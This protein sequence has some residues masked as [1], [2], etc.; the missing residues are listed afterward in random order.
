MLWEIL[1]AL[2]LMMSPVLS[3][4]AEELWQHMRELDKSLLDSVQLGDWPQISEQEYDRELLARWE[5][6]LEIR[7]EAMIALEAAKSCHECD[8][9]LEARLIIYAEP[10]ILELLNGFQPLEML[11][12]VSAVELRP[13]EQAPPEA[14]GQ[15]MYIRAEKN[16]GQ[17]CERCWMRLESVNL[18]PAY[19]GLCARCAAKVAQ[20]VRTD[21][22]E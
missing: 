9:P 5:R 22:N 17:K 16:A 2:T 13:L 21:G 12:I 11:M 3:F 6:F 15:E 4:T 1:K 7:H 10:E 14:S 8:N 19:S 18:D 20:L